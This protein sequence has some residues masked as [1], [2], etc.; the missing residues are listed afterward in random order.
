MGEG[1]FEQKFAQSD[2]KKISL[3]PEVTFD[4]KVTPI[5][6]STITDASTGESVGEVIFQLNLK[7]KV[8]IVQDILIEIDR[9]RQGYGTAVY[10]SIQAANPDYTFESSGEMRKKDDPLQEK[11]NAVLFWEGLVESGLAEKREDGTFR[12]KKTPA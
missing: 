6:R 11:P 12:M 5:Y 9:K 3:N 7:T 10:Q 8:I 1:D 2:G 4:S